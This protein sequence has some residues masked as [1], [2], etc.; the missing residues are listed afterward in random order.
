MLQ[1]T[2]FKSLRSTTPQGTTSV[3]SVL[4]EIGSDL[5]RDKVTKV[6]SLPL[7]EMS[8]VKDTLPVF[9][10]TGIFSHRSIKGLQ[11]YNGIITLDIDHVEDPQA[12]KEVC[13]TIPW[14]WAAFI[15]PSG[16]GLK[17]LVKTN[18]TPQT[19]KIVEESV[20]ATFADATGFQRDNRC[21]DIARIQ[22]VSYDPQ[23]YINHKAENVWL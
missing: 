18:A 1:C 17:V 3:L 22:F 6:R 10:P 4:E 12:L 9:T 21:K 11:E 19:Y 15:T 16:K 23:I 7:S 2:R 8:K 5:Y 20:A 14:I 13:K